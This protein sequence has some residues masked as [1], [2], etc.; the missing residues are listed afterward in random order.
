MLIGPKYKIA[1]R[2]GAP[3]FEKTQNQKFALS[4]DRK[5]KARGRK[6]GRAKSD[7]G[8][9][10][11]EKQKARYVYGLSE[12]Q[13]RNY[14]LEAIAQKKV[15]SSQYLYSKLERRIDNIVYRAGLARTRR[16]A[17]QMV[18]HGH[19]MVN[20]RRIT[21]PSHILT[22]KDTFKVR[23][24]S[25]TSKLF[26]TLAEDTAERTM[27]NWLAFDINKFEGSLK[28]DPQLKEAQDLLFN[29]NTIIEFY[30][31]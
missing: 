27:P 16:F 4:E 1:R 2:V 31:K 13:F 29:L 10:L 22:T 9:Q 24:Q 21:I 25:Q 14:V 19:I 15:P 11:N 6:R 23:P 30:S 26:T 5:M 20:G 18:S 3:V 7:F 17:R 12:K 8:L 28:D